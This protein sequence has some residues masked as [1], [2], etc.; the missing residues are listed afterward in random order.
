MKS[1]LSF[2]KFYS[3]KEK[4]FTGKEK[5]KYFLSLFKF[6]LKKLITIYILFTE[7]FKIEKKSRSFMKQ[8]GQFYHRLAIFFDIIVREKSDFF[9]ILLFT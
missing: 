6:D 8:Y 7:K 4:I 1:F 3:N 5:S 2:L 9:S